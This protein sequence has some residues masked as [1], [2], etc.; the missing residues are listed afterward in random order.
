[1]TEAVWHEGKKGELV[2]AWQYSAVAVPA[3]PLYDS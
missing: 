3:V 1:M 2:E